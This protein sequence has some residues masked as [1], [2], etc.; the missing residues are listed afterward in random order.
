MQV[1]RPFEDEIT[2][3]FS[4]DEFKTEWYM[5]MRYKLTDLAASVSRSLQSPWQLNME[6]AQN[7]V[8]TTAQLVQ[9]MTAGF[10]TMDGGVSSMS[11][12]AQQ[13]QTAQPA[14]YSQY[15]PATERHWT[16]YGQHTGNAV[17]W[18]GQVNRQ[19]EIENRVGVEQ[20][21]ELLS[22]QKFRIEQKMK[23]F[24]RMEQMYKR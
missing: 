17:P 19:G 22:A 16:E 9:N 5:S 13:G 15:G 11:S 14:Q 18:D 4:S 12:A 7:M 8:N 6:A 3:F 23:V 20:D 24:E 10:Q 2:D 21:E 1:V